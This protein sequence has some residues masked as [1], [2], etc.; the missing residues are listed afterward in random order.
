[1]SDENLEK[2]K[3]LIEEKNKKSSEQ[4]FYGKSQKKTSPS[5]GKRVQNTK[6]GGS[7]NK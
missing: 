1:M 6:K 7:L 2:M 4:G 5:T 3:K